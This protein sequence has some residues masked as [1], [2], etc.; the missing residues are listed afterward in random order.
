MA[1]PSVDRQTFLVNLAKSGLIPRPRLAE[2][3][4]YVPDDEKRGKVLA[5]LLVEQGL[6]T[7]FQAERLL[8]GRT[9]GFVMGQYRILEELGR[10]GMGRVYKA[11]HQTMHRIVALKVLAASLTRTERARQ[12]FQREVRAAAKLVHP[13]IVTAFD[14]NQ[15]GDRLYL[16]M[17]FV[18]GPNLQD[19]VR[20]RGP[21][22]VVQ[23][24]EF[25]RQ[26][27][28][29]L[30]HA[31]LLGMAHRDVKPSNLLVQRSPG[32]PADAP[33]VYQVKIL[34]F[35][36][37]RLVEPGTGESADGTVMGTPDFLAPEQARANSRIDPRS[38]LYSL[39]CTLYYLLTGRVP[40]PGGTALEKL[41]RHGTEDPNPVERLRPDVLWPVAQILR[42]M[43][44]KEPDDRFQSATEVAAALEPY[45]RLEQVEPWL[46]SLHAGSPRAGVPATQTT[47]LPAEIPAQVRTETQL[48]ADETSP[49]APPEDPQATGLSDDDFELPPPRLPTLEEITGK[50]S[51]SWV[52]PVTIAVI[53]MAVG[54]VLGLLTLA[55][56]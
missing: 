28:L 26:A 20:R 25:V 41:V 40:F 2:W 12:L 17:E 15:V 49:A 14:A 18:D 16:V 22:P 30:Q 1:T 6:L 19:L 53:T 29:G 47:P 27:A 31:H 55:K 11:E 33:P 38:D 13:N 39:G 54:F 43:M 45:T 5:R 10:G 36:L 24:C 35:G 32:L 48:D 21:L 56:L 3:L 51:K 46:I 44:A 42:R 8:A 34:D 23:A 9:D 7:R 4:R 50:R 52:L 37:A